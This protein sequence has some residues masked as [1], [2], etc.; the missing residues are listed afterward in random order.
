M[1]SMSSASGLLERELRQAV[2]RPRIRVGDW[3]DV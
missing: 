1:V 3:L 2:R